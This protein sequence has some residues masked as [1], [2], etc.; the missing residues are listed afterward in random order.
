M[1]EPAE[2]VAVGGQS[3]GKSS[4][5]EAL[6]GFRFN[7]RETEM[8]TRRPL[9]VQMSHDPEATVPRICLQNE[10]DDAY[11]PPITPETA[12]VDAIRERT[13]ALLRLTGKAV[14]DKP[15]VMRAEYAYCPNLTLIDTPGLINT[16]R[17][18]EP[19]S[20]PQ[21]IDR[22]VRDAI[23]PANRIVLF[24][25]QSSVEW[26]SSQ[27]LRKVR[28]V[29]PSFART[30]VVVSKFDNRLK[31]LH[32]RREADTYLG[33]SGYLP[34]GVRPFYVALP[35]ERYGHAS[36]AEDFRARVLATD[37]GVLKHLQ[38]KVAGGFDEAAFGDRIGFCQLRRHL[39][40]ELQGRYR[41]AM[42]TILSMVDDRAT[43]AAAELRDAEVALRKV[44]D[45]G[46][47]RTATMQ[48]GLTALSQVGPLLEGAADPDPMAWGQTTQEERATCGAAAWPGV[49]AATST[50]PAGAKFKLH[51]G[52]AFNRAIEELARAAEA[53]EMPTSSCDKVVNVLLGLQGGMTDDALSA[54]AVDVARHA[55]QQSLGPLLDTACD[56][57]AH[58]VRRLHDLAVERVRTAA[59]APP[60]PLGT[61]AG[62]LRQS[63]DRFVAAKAAECKQLLRHHLEVATS[64]YAFPT[65]P[66][67]A[68][69]TR[70]GSVTAFAAFP[71]PLAPAPAGE[72]LEAA[73][74]VTPLAIRLEEETE[75]VHPML[76]ASQLGEIPETPEAEQGLDRRDVRGKR[77]SALAGVGG[78]GS[79]ARGGKRTRR[80]GTNA[81][82]TAVSSPASAAYQR[83]CSEAEDIFDQMRGT[84][85]SDAVPTALRAGFL[86]PCRERLVHEVATE[87]FARTD[88]DFLRDFSPAGA[89]ERLR[90]EHA[91]CQKRAD[92]LASMRADFEA[93]AAE[94]GA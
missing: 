58:I 84:L 8:G 70:A 19:A 38:E 20:T 13:E 12:V 37:A 31:E 34:A 62:A 16:A 35:T 42:P 65:G 6:L 83:V 53:L 59:G 51:G 74:A 27:W 49:P 7:V 5:L 92:G 40:A 55:L 47:L 77:R 21:E 60:Q 61:F 36:D 52:S 66:R 18:G 3:D 25:Q 45:V 30:M 72:A 76:A 71:D 89:L 54:V 29:D 90:A 1:P 22:M 80:A 57:L 14:S 10:H 63:Y 79:P 4:L 43:A 46:A 17:E 26:N 9:L 86:T 48:W 81:A 82:T 11:G 91:A 93:T 67:T 64:R 33:A 85:L 44:D 56:R 88:E 73:P 75:N 87:L 24:L 69:R 94:L 41:D 32:E 39:L 50:L 2:I 23:T 15:I 28:E 78:V 68:R